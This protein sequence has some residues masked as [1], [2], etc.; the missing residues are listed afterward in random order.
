MVGNI[1]SRNRSSEGPGLAHQGADDVAVIDVGLPFTAR[2]APCVPPSGPLPDAPYKRIYLLSY[3]VGPSGCLDGAPLA[4]PG[5][6]V[7]VLRHGSDALQK[8]AFLLQS[9]LAPLNHLPAGVGLGSKSRLAASGPGPNPS[10]GNEP[11]AIL[12]AIPRNR[13]VRG[14]EP[15]VLQELGVV[16]VEGTATAALYLMGEGRAVV[17]AY[18][19]GRAAQF[20]ER[21]LQPL[22]QGHKG[23][24]GNHLGVA[25][26]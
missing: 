22:L 13:S 9:L 16:V 15:V 12:V 10:T 18:D 14:L 26:P 21:V 5:L 19:L 20:P 3:G 2:P 4:H 7:D 11:V 17:G 1:C 8:W 24:A 25:P 6:V 23:L